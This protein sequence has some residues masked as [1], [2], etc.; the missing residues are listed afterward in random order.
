MRVCGFCH[1]PLT[2]TKIGSLPGLYIHTSTDVFFCRDEN[3]EEHDCNTKNIPVTQ[4]EIPGGEVRRWWRRRKRVREARRVENP[5]PGV[6][7]IREDWDDE[8]GAA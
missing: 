5:A 2:Y 1:K 6:R 8:H 3:G 7:I 4:W